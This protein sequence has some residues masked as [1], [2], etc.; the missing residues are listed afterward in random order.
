MS[1]ASRIIAEID[2]FLDKFSL[3]TNKLTHKDLIKFIEE[4][5]KEADDEK[6][7]IHQ[8]NI[9]I[10]RMTNEYIWANDLEN[11]MR[12]L[13]IGDLHTSSTKN[14]AYINNYYK[15]ECC[16]ECGNEEKALEFFN[17]SYSEDP[18]YIFTR[19][20]FCYQFFNKH[21][22]N[23][24]QLPND[25]YDYEDDDEDDDYSIQLKYW[26]DFFK[27]EDNE[28][29]FSVLKNDAETYGK[30]NKKNLNGLKYLQDNQE[31]ILNN[32]LNTLLDKYP[33]L[34]S[35]YNYSEEDKKDFMPDLTNING[36]ADLL[37]LTTF[38]IISV[39]KDD[40]P[41]M[42]FDFSCSWDSEHGLGIMTHKDRVIEIDGAETAFATYIAKDD[43]KQS[44]KNK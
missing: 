41:Y 30:L 13:S 22:E 23:P 33:A 2:L 24:R 7:N 29:H 28:F 37:S 34:Q 38:Y 4:K 31:Q 35:I 3:K 43:L 15:G 5:W 18:E 27:E 26:K 11:M 12:W 32:I 9:I 6:Y 25:D 21:L 20:P 1:N 42:G 40:I 10:G 14:P 36:F 39:Y 17:L 8:S 16:L 44:K 19:A